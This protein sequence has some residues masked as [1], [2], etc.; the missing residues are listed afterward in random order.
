MAPRLVTRRLA[1]HPAGSRPR[2]LRS[3]AI[4]SRLTTTT[5]RSRPILPFLFIPRSSPNSVRRFTSERKRWWK[6]EAKL[7]VRY[8]L[9]LWGVV[10]CVLTI[11]F[12]FNEEA[13]EREFPTPPEWHYLTRK[14]LRDANNFKDPKNGHIN[15]ARALEL[16]RGVVI[17]LEDPAVDGQDVVKLSDAVDPRLEVPGEFI[18]CDISAKSEEWRRGYFE[19]I[20][21]AAKAAEHVDGWLRDTTRNIVT[22]PEFVIGPS[23]PHPTPIPPGNPSAPREE[24]CET[25]YPSA[26]NWYTKIL[27]TKGL[28]PRQKVQACL[29]FASFME[30]KNNTEG[31]DSLYQLALAEATSGLDPRKLPYDPMTLILKERAEPPSLNLLDALTA[32]ANHIARKGDVTSALPIY[33]SIL[34]ARR[35][36]SDDPPRAAT[37]K[38]KPQSFTRQILSFFAPPDYPPPP[39][40]GTQPPWRSPFERCQ[41]AALNLYIGEILYATGSKD[42]GLAWTRDGVDLAEEQLRSPK[43]SQDTAREAKSTCRNCLSTGLDNWSVMVSRLARE[44]KKKKASGSPSSMF[45][46]WSGG[47][48]QDSESRW[49]AEEVV[50]QD[51]M[52]RTRELLEDV[53]APKPGIVSFF[54]V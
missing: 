29:E 33:L 25:A 12:A 2:C 30:F 23:N 39:P 10:I 8:T 35:S 20:M 34:K 51:R 46:F 14:F 54:K 5:N 13:I 17:R 41:E 38:R 53:Q 18:A 45:S 3:F 15:W 47:S 52:K 11:F 40:D 42:D 27:A 9:T 36:L 21:L 26:D 37:P 16:S 32:T 6:H 50:I 31:A 24:D 4:Q 7:V 22:P 1:L 43:L 19:A 28:T 44:E 49:E 48:S